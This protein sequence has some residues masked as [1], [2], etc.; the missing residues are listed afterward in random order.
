MLSKDQHRRRRSSAHD[1]WR[2]IQIIGFV[3]E[4]PLCAAAWRRSSVVQLNPGLDF[5]A[6]VEAEVRPAAAIFIAAIAEYIEFNG[7]PARGGAD[8]VV[9]RNRVHRAPGGELEIVAGR[10]HG[11]LEAEI[12]RF[13]IGCSPGSV[14]AGLFI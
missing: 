10:R 11:A 7:L 4:P 9:A 5:G 8:R 12:T 13:W 14:I 2:H 3:G 1:P 6:S